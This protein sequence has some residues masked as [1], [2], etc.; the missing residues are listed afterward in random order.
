MDAPTWAV[1]DGQRRMMGWGVL[2]L[3]LYDLGS[4]SL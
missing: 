1:G 3:A 4:Q 2:E